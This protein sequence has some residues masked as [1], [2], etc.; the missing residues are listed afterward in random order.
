[1]RTKG[2]C[3]LIVCRYGLYASVYTKNIDRA[4]RFAKGLEAVSQLL[5]RI[6]KVTYINIVN[7]RKGHSR[8]QLHFSSDG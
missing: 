5:A 7:Q 8:R 6:A 3:R 2:H 1:V 4:L